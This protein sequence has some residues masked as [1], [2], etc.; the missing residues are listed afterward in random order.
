MKGTT[1]KCVDSKCLL[2]STKFIY[3]IYIYI[4]ES[5]T[6]THTYNVVLFLLAHGQVYLYAYF[7][8][9]GHKF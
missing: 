6:H 7:W 8:L 2:Y 9:R 4:Y 5:E 1:R 3:N